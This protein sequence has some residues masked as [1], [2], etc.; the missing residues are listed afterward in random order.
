MAE[1]NKVQ[2][3]QGRIVWWVQG[4]SAVEATSKWILRV[5]G[6]GVDTSLETGTECNWLLKMYLSF[7]VGQPV[8]E[9]LSCSSL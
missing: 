9:P 4:D 8:R 6:T 3:L 2:H 7:G 5:T 1:R